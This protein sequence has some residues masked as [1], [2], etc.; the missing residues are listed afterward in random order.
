MY[1]QVTEEGENAPLH[2]AGAAEKIQK[3]G[4]EDNQDLK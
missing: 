1:I 3:K 2:A 4:L